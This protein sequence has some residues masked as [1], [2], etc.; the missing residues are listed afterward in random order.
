MNYSYAGFHLIYILPAIS[1]AVEFFNTIVP[2]FPDVL[3]FGNYADID[4][5][6]LPFMTGP[7][8]TRA[9]PLH[10]PLQKGQGAVR[11]K[12]NGPVSYTHL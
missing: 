6:V 3:S 1:A 11:A 2:V 9:N 5:P 4:K 12:G 8:R 7:E 10:R